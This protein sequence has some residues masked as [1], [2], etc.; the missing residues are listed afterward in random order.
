M[1]V[2]VTSEFSSMIPEVV[3]CDSNFGFCVMF[4]IAASFRLYNSI[5][6]NHVSRCDQ[7]VLSP[8]DPSFMPDTPVSVCVILEPREDFGGISNA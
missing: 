3:E 2:R 7:Y 6:T 5:D 1:R 4:S 8:N